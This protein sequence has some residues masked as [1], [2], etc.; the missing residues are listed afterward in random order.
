[1][2]L[3]YGIIDTIKLIYPILTN[4]MFISVLIGIIILTVIYIYNSRIIKYISLFLSLLGIGFI[5]HYYLN[6]IIKFNFNNPIN[7]I[8]FYFYNSIIFLIIS[9]VVFFKNKYRDINY[10]CYC[11]SVIN[12][13][14]SIYM[15]SYLH[16]N[17]LIV[18]GNIFPMIKFGNILYMFYYIFIIYII[19]RQIL[20]HKKK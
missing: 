9:T 18:I 8:Y 1:M 4:H 2:S 20:C 7:N 6:D 13:S 11:I 14:Y 3:N 15:T 12:I 19:G 10:V 16:N 17:T 5:L